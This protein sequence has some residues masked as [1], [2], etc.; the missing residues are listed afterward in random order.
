MIHPDFYLRARHDAD[1]NLDIWI[2]TVVLIEFQ[3]IGSKAKTIEQSIM[4]A[5]HANIKNNIT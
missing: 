1:H 2:I 3:T 4:R 5:R